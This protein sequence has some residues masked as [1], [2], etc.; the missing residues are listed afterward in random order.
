[1]KPSTTVPTGSVQ[2]QCGTPPTLVFESNRGCAPETKKPATN[3]PRK[4]YSL[5]AVQPQASRYNVAVQ[6]R[7]RGPAPAAK[8]ES[9]LGSAGLAPQGSWPLCSVPPDPTRAGALP[10]PAGVAPSPAPVSFP[11]LAPCGSA[12]ASFFSSEPACPSPPSREHL[13]LCH[14]KRIPSG[15]FLTNESFPIIKNIKSKPDLL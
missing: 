14:I 9:P 1:M 5:K 13:F 8:K 15:K 2:P 10:P 4:E 11:C 6:L 3:V 12:G 7:A